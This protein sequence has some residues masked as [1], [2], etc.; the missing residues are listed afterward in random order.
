MLPRVV[1]EFYIQQHSTLDFDDGTP[2]RG[3]ELGPWGK[4]LSER[5]RS[6]SEIWRLHQF[7]SVGRSPIHQ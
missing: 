7:T 5:R 1:T 3:S 4:P 2:Q 6:E